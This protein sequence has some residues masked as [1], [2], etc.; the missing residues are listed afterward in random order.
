MAFVPRQGETTNKLYC[1]LALKKKMCNENKTEIPKV[2]PKGDVV[3]YCLK[4][5]RKLALHLRYTARNQYRITNHGRESRPEALL[6]TKNNLSLNRI[7]PF[8]S[9]VLII[10][11]I[12]QRFP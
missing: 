2:M 4:Y 11:Y 6:S 8:S 5:K 1:N 12:L 9:P 7:A 10:D 3:S